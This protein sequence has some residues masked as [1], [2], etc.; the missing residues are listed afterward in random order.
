[1]FNS[2]FSALS[3]CRVRQV[4]ISPNIY[5][6]INGILSMCVITP[7]VLKYLHF[8]VGYIRKICRNVCWLTHKHTHTLYTV[9]IVSIWPTSVTPAFSEATLCLELYLIIDCT[10]SV[11]GVCVCGV[12]C[13][14]R[15]LNFGRLI[16]W[17]DK[18]FAQ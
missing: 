11:P 8:K 7:T 5:Y 12:G 6:L 17:P 1:M 16:A 3:I 2:F 10:S 13:A 14:W 4:L 15:Q 9:H 18:C